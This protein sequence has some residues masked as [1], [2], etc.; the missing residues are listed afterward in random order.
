MG[1]PLGRR[2]SSEVRY[3]VSSPQTDFLLRK[4]VDHLMPD[5]VKAVSR[6]VEILQECSEE[7][8]GKGFFNV[9]LVPISG[10]PYKSEGSVPEAALLGEEPTSSQ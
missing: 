1:G 8:L 9:A 2:S 4:L 7:G 6:V 5:M 10:S 3:L